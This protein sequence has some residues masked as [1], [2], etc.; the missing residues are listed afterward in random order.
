MADT[1]D[2]KDPNGGS[3]PAPSSGSL[4]APNEKITKVNVAEEIKN[5]FLDY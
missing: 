4:F 5:S 2:P 1:N 3:E